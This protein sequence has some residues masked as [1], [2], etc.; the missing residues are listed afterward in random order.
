ML[1]GPDGKALELRAADVD[2]GLV[3][4]ELQM[5]QGRTHYVLGRASNGFALLVASPKRFALGSGIAIGVELSA[6]Q[7]AGLRNRCFELLTSDGT[8]RAQVIP[9]DAAI[10]SEPGADAIDEGFRYL[11]EQLGQGRTAFY[12]GRAPGGYALLVASPRS[13]AVG[14]GVG[15]ALSLSERALKLLRARVVEL[16][17][18]SV[19]AQRLEKSEG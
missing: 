7:L 9:A 1:F 3:E 16:L 5:R 8:T 2:R 12:L 18:G 4:L 13:F 10:L 14:D 15:V 19:I 6:L 11:S 17:H